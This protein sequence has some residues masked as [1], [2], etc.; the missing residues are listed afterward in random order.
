[1][2]CSIE[3]T[4]SYA[5]KS[6]VHVCLQRMTQ[7]A[8]GQRPTGL[9]YLQ[10]AFPHLHW[11]RCTCR[12]LWSQKILCLFLPETERF[13]SGSSSNMSPV[14]AETQSPEITINRWTSLKLC[15]KYHKLEKNLVDSSN[16]FKM[17]SVHMTMLIFFINL[18]QLFWLQ[19]SFTQIAILRQTH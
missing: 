16:S 13:S 7:H 2:K 8:L 12:R 14:Q 19:G 11:R 3:M 1:M 10:S 15:S 18:M 5:Y 4:S 6:R 17:L 9:Q